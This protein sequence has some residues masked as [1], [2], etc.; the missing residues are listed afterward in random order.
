MIFSII[1]NSEL[2]LFTARRIAVLLLFPREGRIIYFAFLSILPF[3][4]SFG[5]VIVKCVYS[6]YSL[7]RRHNHAGSVLTSQSP[8][9]MAVKTPAKDP[10]RKDHF[11]LKRTTALRR[12]KMFTNRIVNN[13]LSKH[14]QEK[15][16]EIFIILYFLP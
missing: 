14:T 16:L 15:S 4:T 1:E 11:V 6:S 13:G 10:A 3:Q 7:S 9:A 5:F 12:T 2:T 8:V